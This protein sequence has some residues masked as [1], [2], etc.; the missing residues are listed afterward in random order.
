MKRLFT[1]FCMGVLLAATACQQAE[2][3]MDDLTQQAVEGPEFSAQIGVFDGDTKTVMD[4]KS[5][6][7]SLGDQ[8]AIFQGT[9]VA[10]KYQVNDDCVGQSKG[11]F[12][13]V[14]K[15]DGA[16]L[17]AFDANVA[18]YPYNDDLSCSDVVTDGGV[19][20]YRIDGIIIPSTQS[21]A[22]GSFTDGSFPMAAVSDGVAEHALS[23]RNLCGVLKLRLKGTATVK[24]IELCGNGEELLSGAADLLLYADGAIPTLTMSV[25]ACKTV[26]VDCG[27][28]VQLSEDAA[29]EFYIAVPPTAF[30]KGFNILITDTEGKIDRLSTSKSNQIKRSC[31]HGMPEIVVRTESPSMICQVKGN[32]VYV[33]AKSFSADNDFVWH[34]RKRYQ[35]NNRFFNIMSM[36]TCPSTTA[37]D[38]TIRYLTKWKGSSDDICPI[39]VN[40]SHIGGNHGHNCVDKLTVTGHGKTIEDIGSIWTDSNGKT[41]V[42]VYVYDDN[43]LGLVKFDDTTMANGKMTYGNPDVGSVMTHVSGATNTGDI[44]IEAREGTQLWKCS[45]HEVLRLYV[46]GIER[47]LETDQIIAAERIE[48]LTE[49]NVIYIP[50]MLTYLMDNVG[51]ND[52]ESQHSEDITDNYFRLSVKY[53]FNR[54]GSISQYNTYDIHKTLALSYCGLVQSMTIATEPYIYS[55][56]TI[57]DALT[58]H[59]DSSNSYYMYKNTWRAADKVPYRYYQFTDETADKGICLA[60]DR[61]YGWGGNNMRLNKIEYAGRYKGESK[62]MYPVFIGGG[63]LEAGVTIEG[64]A[65]RIPLCKQD[66][67]LTAMGWYWLGD[68]I[69]LMIDSHK[70][71]DKDIVLPSYMDG[72]Q[73]EILDKTESVT[74]TQARVSDCKLRYAATDYGYLVVRLFK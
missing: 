36:Y 15:G 35:S 30:E 66:D 29:T 3:P 13:I 9:A 26:A 24:T 63:S 38:A 47:E 25:D 4:G 8:I 60:Y 32:D 22:N 39:Q 14:A 69:V 71:V 43:K 20:A 59:N 27:E 48:L 19:T 16:A 12:S 54:N 44:S 64:L 46:D 34:L 37:D 1:I 65:C 6:L 70:A 45:N 55:P 18:I 7:W 57:Y 61:S 5:V 17:G 67:D 31:I 68:D 2:L 49:Y 11:T 40:G 74:C 41:Y 72:M 21:Y 23:F 51:S 52:A 62:K 33:R 50:S 10:D 28:G 58:L 73:L 42:L 53:Q 56:D